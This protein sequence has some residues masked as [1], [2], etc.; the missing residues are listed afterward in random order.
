[1]KKILI[2]TPKFPYPAR[3]A[4][5]QDRAAGI[6]FFIKSGWEV[7]VITK[8]YGEEYKKD[9]SEANEKLGI[10]IIPINYKYL[11]LS[12]GQKIKNIFLRL[13][14]PWYWDGAA[15]EYGDLN[16]K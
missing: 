11:T 8:I 7:R 2:I 9:V 4:C 12:I 13:V 1:M 3:G 15:R 14:M 16:I 5:E 10:T 6:E